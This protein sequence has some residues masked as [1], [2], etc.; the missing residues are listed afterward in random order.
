M[1]IERGCLAV[2][3]TR[4]MSPAKGAV[5]LVHGFAQNRFTW[6]LPGRSLPRFLAGQGWDVFNVELRGHGQSRI[7]GAPRAERFEDHVEHDIPAVMRLAEHAGHRNVLL[8]GHSLGGAICYAVASNHPERV[9]GCRDPE[10]R[11]SLGRRR[12][13]DATFDPRDSH[14][15]QHRTCVR[16]ARAKHPLGSCGSRFLAS[17][18]SDRRRLGARPRPSL[19]PRFHRARALAAVVGAIDGPDE[20]IGARAHGEVGREWLVH[21]QPGRRR[22]RSPVASG[23][24]SRVGPRRGSGSTRPPSKRREARLRRLDFAPSQLSMLWSRWRWRRLR[25]HRPHSGTPSTTLGLAL[26]RELA[27]GTHIGAANV[28]IH[29]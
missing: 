12:A 14:Q 8:V 23:A 26:Y 4:P 27:R 18:A 16:V 5:I 13:V 20:R 28:R 15:R 17:L 2:I 29:R 24:G 1:P 9:R 25:A 22:L 11:V 19:V 7:Y 3:R 10:R 21:R 6:D